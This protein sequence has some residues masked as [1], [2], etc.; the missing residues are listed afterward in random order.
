[1]AR[2]L[3]EKE[4]K[5]VRCRAD[6][7]GK[8]DSAR[9]A[10]YSVPEVQFA[11]LERRESIKKAIL[12][13]SLDK[14][15][16]ELLPMALN[17]FKEILGPDSAAPSGVKVKAA[18]YITDKAIELQNMANAKDISEKNPLDMTQA[19]LEVFIMRGR[20]VLKEET[21]RQKVLE[22]LG[23]IDIEPEE[24]REFTY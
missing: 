7:L 15:G 21:N 18:S 12:S 8:V 2:V 13:A 5:Y 24:A 14:I 10:G 22:D 3:T 17:T 20:F 11:A 4:K 9:L 16:K 23:V 19:E 6:G 1:M